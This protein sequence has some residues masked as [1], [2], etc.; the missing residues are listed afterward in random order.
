MFFFHFFDVIA[1]FS[2]LLITKDKCF[3][4]LWR[5]FEIRNVGK[6]ICK[7][8]LQPHNHC[9]THQN[10]S[11]RNFFIPRL[12]SFSLVRFWLSKL[13]KRNN[14]RQ[15]IFY[16]FNISDNNYISYSFPL[17]PR[18]SQVYL[19]RFGSQDIAV[20]CHMGSFGCGG[21]GWTLAMKIDGTKVKYICSTN[22][23]IGV[24]YQNAEDV[25]VFFILNSE[26]FP[27]WIALL[28]RQKYL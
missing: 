9:F 13:I 20:Y 27:L 14:S 6:E 8:L 2:C 19:L 16:S 5:H 24:F 12:P 17:R 21:R 23:S 25:Y 10:F 18:R 26:Y 15:F 7:I 4:F 1:L 11:F 3:F 22:K 28:K